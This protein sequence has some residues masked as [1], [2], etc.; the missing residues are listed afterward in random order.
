MAG[1]VRMADA[2]LSL[3][4]DLIT[5]ASGLDINAGNLNTLRQV[6]QKRMGEIGIVNVGDY[7]RRIVSDDINGRELQRLI[8]DLTIN[9]TYFFR[10]PLHFSLLEKSVLPE[11]YRNKILRGEKCTIW[12]A[13]CSTGEEVYSLAIIC[14]KLGMTT[15][16][17]VEIKGSDIDDA[18]IKQALTARYHRRSFRHDLGNLIPDYFIRDGDYL[19]V[20]PLIRKIPTFT[21][22]NLLQLDAEKTGENVFDIIFCRNVFIYFQADVIEKLL[23]DLFRVL[24]PYGLLFLGGAETLNL[25]RHRFSDVILKNTFYYQKRPSQQDISRSFFF[26]DQ[27]DVIST[28]HGNARTDPAIFINQSS[29]YTVGDN[30]QIDKQSPEISGEEMPVVLHPSVSD[31]HLRRATEAFIEEKFLLART[32]CEDLIAIKPDF[33]KAK[34]LLCE[35]MLTMGDSEQAMSICQNVLEKDPLNSEAWYLAGCVWRK[36]GIMNESIQSFRRAFYLDPDLVM[37]HFAIANIF[38]DQGDRKNARRSYLNTINA[39]RRHEADQT[40]RFACG[41]HRDI[42][43]RT[44]ERN[45]E[46]IIAFNDDDDEDEFSPGRV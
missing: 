42:L 5:D 34:I 28:T 35:I 23:G 22:E 41:F 18:A 1:P 13:G 9:E 3:F 27:N 37:A 25:Y 26:S 11:I 10:H 31:E 20:H 15:S 19:I 39:L 6:I 8:N 7:Y 44:C 36:Q 32:M 17:L 40:V 38:R 16:G 29:V 43:I 30:K 24:R 33:S 21:V 4:K 14:Y 12:A 45:L 46:S 2:Q